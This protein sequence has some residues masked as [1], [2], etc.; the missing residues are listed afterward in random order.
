MDGSSAPFVYLVHEAGI[1]TQTERR[2]YL[3]IQRPVF[4]GSGEKSMAVYPADR[5]R[6]SYTIR[7]DHPLVGYQTGTFDV[8]PEIYAAEI[9]P[10]RTFCFLKE[11]EALRQKGLTLGGSLENAIVLDDVSILN[12]KLR[13]PDEFVRH[14]VLDAIGD[15]ALLGLPLL[16]H[17]VAY[18]AGHALH[19]ELVAQLLATP[20]A[21]AIETRAEDS[22][23]AAPALS[24]RLA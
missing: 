9:A 14:K 15:L 4:V 11:V 13:F 18:R 1:R 16:G 17:V 3:R 2:R 7:F 8:T 19:S 21:W 23:T 6:I 22:R 5:F 24:P 12:D 20:E 10:A